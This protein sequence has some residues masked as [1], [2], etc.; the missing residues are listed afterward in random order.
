MP[1][2][3]TKADYRL[4]TNVAPAQEREVPDPVAKN[5]V[6]CG[7]FPHARKD[8]EKKNTFGQ[9]RIHRDQLD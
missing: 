8:K 6:N 7:K 5:S 3:F 2:E 9:Q 4:P 1:L